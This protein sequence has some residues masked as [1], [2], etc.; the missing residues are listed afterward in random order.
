MGAD[1]WWVCGEVDG[2]EKV[3]EIVIPTRREAKGRELQSRQLSRTSW[4]IS[5]A[6]MLI[7]GTTTVPVTPHHRP[8]LRQPVSTTVVIFA[9]GGIALN[10]TMRVLDATTPR[11]DIQTDRLY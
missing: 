1:V 10:T 11:L 2:E 9:P 8:H 3:K 7:F 5:P 4:Q 6:R